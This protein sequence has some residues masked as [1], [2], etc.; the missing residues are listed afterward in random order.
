MPVMRIFFILSC[1]LLFLSAE[2]SS[3]F[4]IVKGK[5]ALDGV[6]TA[7]GV[8]VSVKETKSVAT[9]DDK[10]N[11]SINI[12]KLPA[13][14]VFN[15]AGYKTVEYKVTEKNVLEEII[16]T[17]Y[18]SRAAMEEV[19]VVGY[20]TARKK[21]VTGSVSTIRTESGSLRRTLEGRVSGLSVERIVIAEDK[22]TTTSKAASKVTNDAWKPGK[23]NFRMNY[24]NLT[25]SRSSFS[26]TIS[27]LPRKAG[28][29]ITSW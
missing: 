3:P 5:V 15:Y 7:A 9:T 29:P 1:I 24:E 10:G 27:R 16:V 17:L 2:V 21:D 28:A 14:L 4:I 19:V 11:F 6:G 22:T 23:L 25:A 26:R 18:A 20:A 8:S 13:T 12:I